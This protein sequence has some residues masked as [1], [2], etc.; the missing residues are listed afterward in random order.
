MRLHSGN[1][2][3]AQM[4]IVRAPYPLRPRC[5]SR[6]R[7]M[8]HAARTV[9]ARAR[10]LETSAEPDRPSNQESAMGSSLSRNNRKRGESDGGGFFQSG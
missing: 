5:H 9:A 10:S 8:A 3:T 6:G 2:A 4:C 7:L 1:R